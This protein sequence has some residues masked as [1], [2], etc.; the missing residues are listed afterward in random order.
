MSRT[1]LHNVKFK[2]LKIRKTDLVAVHPWLTHSRVSGK[3]HSLE[4]RLGLLEC[5]G[6]KSYEHSKFSLYPPSLPLVPVWERQAEL[7]QLSDKTWVKSPRGTKMQM[8]RHM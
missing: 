7:L 2:E 4:F 5:E 3:Q 8:L 6:A 1:G